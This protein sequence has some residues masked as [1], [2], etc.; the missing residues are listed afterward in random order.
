MRVYA[1]QAQIGRV[2]LGMIAS[3]ALYIPVRVHSKTVD[4][5]IVRCLQL[6]GEA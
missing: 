6:F 4:A 5:D 3:R 1:C 2:D